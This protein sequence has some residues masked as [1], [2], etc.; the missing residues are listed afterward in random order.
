MECIILMD[1]HPSKIALV[2]C[3]VISI[4][5][6]A[7][8]IAIHFI[9]IDSKEYYI[10]GL[11]A[12]IVL[13]PLIP[14][15]SDSRRLREAGV[16]VWKHAMV[17]GLLTASAVTMSFLSSS[18]LL[19]G[20]LSILAASF[21]WY[22][23]AY[24]SGWHHEALAA[25]STRVSRACIVFLAVF[26]P[27]YLFYVP[28]R[29]VGIYL[30]P[31]WDGTFDVLVGVGVMCFLAFALLV[32]KYRANF[33][34]AFVLLYIWYELEA[35]WMMRNW[36]RLLVY[37]VGT[38]AFV[39]TT[40]MALAVNTAFALGRFVGETIRLSH[41]RRSGLLGSWFPTI[42]AIL[43]RRD[44][45]S[46][47]ARQKKALKRGIA[48]GALLVAIAVPGIVV[49][50]SLFS[51]PITITPRD[52]YNMGFSFWASSN[53]STYSPA[54][55]ATLNNHSANLDLG[56]S[57][58]DLIAIETAMPNVTYRIVLSPP[59][60]SQLTE[61]II[62]RTEEILP[63]EL[64]NTLTQ[65][66]GFAFDIEGTSFGVGA[67]DSPDDAVAEWNA[68]FDY[69]YNNASKRRPGQRMIEMENVGSHVF[70]TDVP[71]DGDMDSQLIEGYVSNEP[72][73]FTSYAPMIYRC[74]SSDKTATSATS[75]LLSP[76]ATSY[77]IY[78]SLYTL[79][80]TVGNESRLGVYIGVT[81]DSCYSRDLVQP[82]PITWGAPGGFGN[83]I[84]DTLIAKH[85]GVPEVT[86]FLQFSVQ[87]Q[88]CNCPEFGAF[89][90]YGDRFLDVMNDS[91][92]KYPP[93]QFNIY[94]NDKDAALSRFT[95]R[96][97][98]G[99][100][101]R[102]AGMAFVVVAAAGSV[103]AALLVERLGKKAR[104]K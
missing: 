41:E 12:L 74:L 24:C 104:V 15:G 37:H 13:L 102:P 18:D 64:S 72:V 10:A 31:T 55:I 20:G 79:H 36:D 53:L 54:V 50:S 51:Y 99:D 33:I 73:R 88:G 80:N 59:N 96:D 14:L 48:I 71:F 82:D 45:P 68:A 52:D 77:S 84:R 94:Y 46:I 3:E 61:T 95:Y 34:G 83:L 65:W 103:C 22:L 69:V 47:D 62:Q 97:V 23:A 35:G 44:R 2:C 39:I 11:S 49:S 85:F 81:N 29:L 93:E 8:Q 86:F 6:A 63:Y 67:F 16:V 57:I 21:L 38:L 78:D 100:V 60:F 19:V 26:L 87:S 76:W 70:G 66:R 42:F 1:I 40:M 17:V 98:L 7:S 92:N 43:T 91:V 9:E 75:S 5:L 32:S 27:L 58:A 101:S 89:D 90:S 28:L 56:G 30:M 25:M 4:V